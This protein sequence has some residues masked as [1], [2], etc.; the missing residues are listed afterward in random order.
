M[1]KS[2]MWISRVCTPTS[3][4]TA[5]TP[6]VILRSSRTDL[7]PSSPTSVLPRSR[8][9]L[10]VV[11]ITPCYRIVPTVNSSSPCAVPVPTSKEEPFA[12]AR[13][14]R[15]LLLERGVPRRY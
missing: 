3:T 9:W 10:H 12:D 14:N 8:C 4:N 2:N 7:M 11:S 15:G 6:W 5:G 1:S 13:T